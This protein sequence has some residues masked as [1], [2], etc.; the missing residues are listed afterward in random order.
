MVAPEAFVPLDLAS[1]TL[2]APIPVGQEPH[3]VAVTPD[4]RMA[5]VTNYASASVT[6]ID[7]ATRVAEPNIDAG[8][9]P[10]AIA[11]DAAPAAAAPAPVGGSPSPGLTPVKP[12]IHVL[13]C[14]VPHLGRT[15]LSTIRKR[16]RR[17]HCRLGRVRYRHS[18]RRRGHDVSQTARPGERLPGSAKIGVV[19]SRGR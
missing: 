10:S 8:N 15:A 5:Y 13:H 16:L 11:I 3:S 1:G 2:G 6:P 19:L 18:R 4:G 9:Y 7:L 17:N 12:I 14:V